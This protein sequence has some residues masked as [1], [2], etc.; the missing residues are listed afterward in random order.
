MV[1][2][3]FA[4]DIDIQNKEK[5]EVEKSIRHMRNDML[6]L[7]VLVFR[8][9]GLEDDRHRD[10]ILMEQKFIGNLKVRSAIRI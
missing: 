9:R 8:E 10:N 6:K 2:I 1:R 4:G 5:G 7:N 3:C